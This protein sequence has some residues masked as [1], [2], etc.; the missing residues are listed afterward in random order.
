[1]HQQ[2]RE[3]KACVSVEQ[4]ERRVWVDAK[5]GKNDDEDGRLAAR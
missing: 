1:L 4:A 5:K 3:D 2:I